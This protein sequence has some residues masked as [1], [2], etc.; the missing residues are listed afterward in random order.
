VE[1]SGGGDRVINPDHLAMLAASGITPEHAALRGYETIDDKRRLAQIK[2]VRDVRGRVPGL[3]VPLLRNDG[4]VWGWQYRPDDPRQRE[5]KPIKYENPWGQ[6]LGLDF[7]PGIE[8]MLGDPAIPL[9]VT[10]GVKKADCAV[11][12]GLCAV[13][14]IGTWGF[15]GTNTAGG[16]MALADWR[17]VAI[18]N[19]RRVII[20][21]DGDLARKPSVRKAM[22]A[23][24]AYLTYRGAKVEYQWLPDTDKKTGLDDYLMDGHT[25]G[26][27]W[28]LV[29]PVPPPEKPEQQQQPQPKPAPAPFG[30]IDGAALLDDVDAYLSK[31][32][33]YPSEHMR[34]ARRCPGCGCSLLSIHLGRPRASM[35]FTFSP[36]TGRGSISA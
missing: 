10:E 15:L 16:K 28:R 4:S 5:G 19:D 33:I 1:S 7:P 22:A 31:Y 36:Q 8:P 3:L 11:L 34:H 12:H 29:K 25:V 35:S 24:A 27:L 23:L 17:D 6:R 13:G 2:I 9:W 32:V 20:A 30:S 21:Y 18:N 14:L 26:D